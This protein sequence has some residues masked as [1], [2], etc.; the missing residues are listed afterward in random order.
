[1]KV[2]WFC[3]LVHLVSG[4]ELAPVGRGWCSSKHEFQGLS[5]WTV[6]AMQSTSSQ[7][8]SM[9]RSG[10]STNDTGSLMVRPPGCQ[11]TRSAQLDRRSRTSGMCECAELQGKVVK[12]V[13]LPPFPQKKWFGSNSPEVIE[14]RR[15]ELERWLSGAHCYSSYPQ[16]ICSAHALLRVCLGTCRAYSRGADAGVFERPCV[17]GIPSCAAAVSSGTC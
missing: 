9:G 4:T 10:L 1:M 6:V 17:P 15:V 12:S 8:C 2:R 13:E 3:A 11:L 14:Q 5:W 7:S 16:L